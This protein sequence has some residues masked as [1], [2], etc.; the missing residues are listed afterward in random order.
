MT[1]QEAIQD[2]AAGCQTIYDV[3]RKIQAAGCS[4]EA[5]NLADVCASCPVASYLTIKCDKKIATNGFEAWVASAPTTHNEEAFEGLT[6]LPKMIRRFIR[7]RDAD[8]ASMS[9]RFPQLSGGVK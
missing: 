6:T 3:A 7:E 2:L 5:A 8:A 4:M 1:L 9:A